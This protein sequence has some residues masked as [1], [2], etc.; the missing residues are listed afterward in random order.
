LAE[1]NGRIHLESMSNRRL[2]SI[3]SV[4]DAKLA[5]DTKEVVTDGNP[6]YKGLL[7]SQ[8]HAP[9]NHGQ[10]LA[11]RVWITTQTIENAFSLFKRAIVGNYH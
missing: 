1:R 11:E 4:P 10:E 5:M 2:E 3:K 7:A 8:K 9:G 6:I